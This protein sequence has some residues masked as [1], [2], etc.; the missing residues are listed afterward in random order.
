MFPNTFFGSLLL[1][2]C[3]LFFF[4]LHWRKSRVAASP[5]SWLHATPNMNTV[6]CSHVHLKMNLL[7][8]EENL[9]KMFCI[10]LQQHVKIGEAAPVNYLWKKQWK[11]HFM[12]AASAVSH[13][14]CWLW[15]VGN[16]SHQIS[17]FTLCFFYIQL[18]LF[19]PQVKWIS[20]IFEQLNLHN[21][22]LH[23]NFASF[24]SPD[25]MTGGLIFVCP[26]IT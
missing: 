5:P 9:Q 10:H 4:S 22:I 17:F 11:Y 24:F 20:L 26:S 6:M 16:I 21:T 8:T 13:L 14:I 2:A 7:L 15:H 3:N 25:N 12:P 19:W 1:S 23:K 18:Y